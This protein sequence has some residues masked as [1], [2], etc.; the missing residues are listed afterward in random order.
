MAQERARRGARSLLDHV[1]II[2]VVTRR[3]LRI[4]VFF[5][6]LLADAHAAYEAVFLI[7]DR[8]FHQHTPLWVALALLA[9]IDGALVWLTVRVGRRLWSE[10]RTWSRA[11]RLGYFVRKK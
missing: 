7:A 9:V 3:G 6:L 11:V 4:V 10:S 2:S 8:G 1:S 5:V